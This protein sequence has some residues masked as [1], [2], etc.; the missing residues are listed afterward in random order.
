MVSPLD[1]SSSR[2]RAA[3]PS[4][5][6]PPPSCCI[7]VFPSAR[8]RC[9]AA[10]PRARA[11]INV[12]FPMESHARRQIDKLLLSLQESGALNSQFKNVMSLEDAASP[13]FGPEVVELF[14]QNTG[15]N[16]RKV[17]GYLEAPEGAN[18]EEISRLSIRM[19]GCNATFGAA[20]LAEQCAS[21][22]E[23]VAARDW[24]GCVKLLE[25]QEASLD[26]LRGHLG[27]FLELDREWKDAAAAAAPLSQG[28]GAVLD[29]R[30]DVVKGS[31]TGLCGAG[32]SGGIG[33]SAGMTAAMGVMGIPVTVAQPGGGYQ[34]EAPVTTGAGTTSMG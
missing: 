7:F 2:A 8:F 6:P 10:R 16:L 27:R 34:E 31:G 4:C 1:T 23:V 13:N 15:E 21:F 24:E 3:G 12:L 28:Q 30:G 20:E 29:T 14:L 32:S 5:F 25:L 19:K 22:E 9:R 11:R 26:F 17:R 33:V 18:Y